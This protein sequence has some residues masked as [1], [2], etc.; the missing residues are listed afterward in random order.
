MTELGDI[1]A[2]LGITHY[3]NDFVEQGFDSWDTILDITES[4]FDAL[5]VKLGHRRKLQ[6]RIAN[7]RGLSSDRALDSSSR[8]TPTD[9]RVSDEQRSTGSR[10]DNKDTGSGPHGAKR[11]YRRHPKPD[12]NAPERPPSAYVIFSNKM[13]EELKGR[14]LS[15]TE[16][17]KLV[18]ENWQNLTPGEK[19]PYEQQAFTAKERYN[20]ELAEYKKT[21]Q[22]KEYSQ[23]LA[24]FKARQSNQQQG[25]HQNTG[26]EAFESLLLTS[27]VTDLDPKRPKLEPHTSTASSG[28][29]SSGASLHGGDTAMGRARVESSASSTSQWPLHDGHPSPQ[30]SNLSVTQATSKGQGS[31]A[32]SSPGI[33][34]GYR[35]SILNHQ[36]LP[37][38]EGQRE[39]NGL[40]HQQLPRISSVG[41]RR[42]SHSGL[43]VADSLNLT[44][45]LQHAH[46]TGHISQTNP[47]PLLSSESTNRSTGSSSTTSSAYFTPRTP[48]EPTIDRPLA[49]PSLFPQKSPGH[50]ENQLPP[51]RP[52]SL[53]PRASIL[54]PQQSPNGSK[55]LMAFSLLLQP[56]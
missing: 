14:N 41:G 54:N 51:L 56:Y 2:E 49:I 36:T 1:F 19:E 50:Y 31:P 12:E 4:D 13:R 20:S 29:A 53:S 38:R 34:P 21:S 24:E 5:G 44:G 48:M 23:Y 11:K 15:F 18:G 7:F 47:P 16:I 27:A 46:R 6:R 25:M 45:S 37:W 8:N 10:N 52:P 17:A 42:R 30:S 40:P 22:Y 26:R 33:L 43:P 28:T 32:V 9:D 39:E 55:S 35:E 3:L